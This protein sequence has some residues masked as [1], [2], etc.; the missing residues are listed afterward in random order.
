MKT[1]ILNGSP[2]RNGDSAHI[3]NRLVEELEGEVIIVNVC[4]EEIQ[5][6]IDC[7]YCWD[8]SDCSHQDAMFYIY[9]LLDV[10]DNVVLSS[11]VYF[12]E[13]SGYLLTYA[14]R[15]QR[16]Y[17]E[18]VLR[19][20]HEFK[21]KAKKGALILAAGGDCKDIHRPIETADIIFRHINTISVGTI[22]TMQT[23]SIPASQDTS[24][25]FQIESIAMLLNAG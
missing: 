9:D 12:S 5:G 7:R 25:E 10:V 8:A 16:Y 3:I 14:T 19:K 17:A 23:N 24:L 13:L 21:M 11:P 4:E 15:F 18:R 1:L 22:Y 6:C 2:R 20:D